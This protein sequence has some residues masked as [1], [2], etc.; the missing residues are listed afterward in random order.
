MAGGAPNSLLIAFFAVLLGTHGA[1]AVKFTFHNNCRE[2]VWPATLTGAGHPP[3]PTAGFALPPGAS[4][5]FPS[6]A[7]T[8]SGRMWGRSRCTT[9][10]AG[11]FSCASGDCGTRQV[12]CNGAGGAAP[13]TLAEFT[14]GGGKTDFYDVSNV[15]GFNLP[16]AIEP[17]GS[18]CRAASCPADINRACPPELAVR[19]GGAVVGCRSACLAFGTDEYCCR[20]RFGSPAT[21]AP[22]RYAR[23]FKEQC[24]QAYSYAYDDGTSTFTCNAV[25][26]YQ[27]TF[28]PAAAP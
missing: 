1:T 21:C 10:G 18:G 24:P 7:P 11:V 14:L 20:G 4:L 16:V 3:F 8:W 25:A 5:S 13:P 2:T 15:D 26:D 9:S 17:S 6:V 12:A 27:V 22:S 23:L 19:S 28:C